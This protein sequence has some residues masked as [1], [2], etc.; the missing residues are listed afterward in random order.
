M[1]SLLPA[2]LLP[3]ALAAAAPPQQ[4]GAMVSVADFGALGDGDH[5][6]VVVVRIG[7]GEKECQRCGRLA[8][9]RGR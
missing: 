2:L 1:C 4:Q 6:E 9:G 5:D 7:L 8:L 3:A